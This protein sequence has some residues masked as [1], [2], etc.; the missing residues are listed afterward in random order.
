MTTLFPSNKLPDLLK[1]SLWV[2][3][4]ATSAV[5]LVG[6]SKG[7]INRREFN[8]HDVVAWGAAGV[9]IGAKFGVDKPFFSNIWY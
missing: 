2:G 1:I 7:V 9:M 5:L 4:C 3:A 8:W 6:V